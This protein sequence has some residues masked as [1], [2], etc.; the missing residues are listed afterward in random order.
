MGKKRSRAAGGRPVRGPPAVQRLNEC[1]E[2]AVVDEV[3]GAGGSAGAVDWAALRQGLLEEY[4]GGLQ[5]FRLV[6]ELGRVSA[7]MDLGD[8][9]KD[10]FVQAL[11][12]FPGEA[13][14]KHALASLSFSS[15]LFQMGRFETSVEYLLNALE[16]PPKPFEGWEILLLMDLILTEE[17]TTTNRKKNRY[18]RYLKHA[19]SDAFD[20]K[21]LKDPGACNAH[22]SAHAWIS[23]PSTW[24]QVGKQCARHGEFF[25]ARKCI[26]RGL[27][28]RKV[29]SSGD[30]WECLASIYFVENN[31]EQAIQAAGSGFEIDPFHLGIR[32]RLLAWDPDQ[33]GYYF[34]QE[35]EAIAGIQSRVR[36]MLARKRF[37]RI[38]DKRCRERMLIKQITKESV[39]IV[40]GN[41]LRSAFV[42]H[43]AAICIQK[44]V[45]RW[46][47]QN[48]VGKLKYQ[49]YLDECANKIQSCYR[50]MVVRRKMKASLQRVRRLRLAATT[51]QRI[52]RGNRG[53]AKA[54][55]V[56][57]RLCQAINIQ[58][59]TR[60]MFG[61][62]VARAIRD[63]HSVMFQKV[64]RGHLVRIGVRQ[65]TRSR[66]HEA[67]KL[68]WT[69]LEWRA[70]SLHHRSNNERGGGGLEPDS[71]FL[72]AE[73]VGGT[74]YTNG[75]A[76]S[77][78]SG[79]EKGRLTLG[80]LKRLFLL[81]QQG[82]DNND[83]E[84]L[85]L[86]ELVQAMASKLPHEQVS[87]SL[88]ELGLGACNTLSSTGMGSL[89]TALHDGA[90]QSLGV[91]HIENFSQ[92]S[93]LGMA[94]ALRLKCLQTSC[95]H[96]ISLVSG[97]IGDESCR[98]IVNA[99]KGC[100][101]LRTLSLE[102][103]RICDRGAMWLT[104]LFQSKSS[105]LREI[106]LNGNRIADKGVLWLTH[107]MQRGV[108]HGGEI[109]ACPIEKLHL[110]RNSISNLGA[111]GIQSALE[112]ADSKCKL[113]VVSLGRNFASPHIL[114]YIAKLCAAN[115]TMSYHVPSSPCSSY[116]P[117][118]LKSSSCAKSTSTRETL[119]TFGLL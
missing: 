79:A 86:D 60:G 98:A 54:H 89:F 66:Q 6:W 30:L 8:A 28:A 67:R 7:C 80:H 35:Q 24:E 107:A 90:C 48:K 10:Y 23:A 73:M 95:I 37:R 84:M 65:S 113:F 39:D 112:S 77:V 56:K 114:A 22:K 92:I 106:N 78:L 12:A 82:N 50:G 52:F 74:V 29:Q 27:C 38:A 41:A 51:I 26:I 119:L 49:L 102:N 36:S 104:H 61:R 88:E 25:L 117:Y 116:R 31:V 21:R 71:L 85:S 68:D 58:R 43:Q 5:S 1:R 64:C 62:H 97:R 94:S 105:C 19:Y 34:Q 109:F 3:L 118:Y 13:K 87:D 40:I 32:R 46:Q 55:R 4:Q 99:F 42:W 16:S 2:R 20:Q 100:V 59:V 83:K 70:R 96:T 57:E 44:N 91:L 81:G 72:V 93:D 11:C 14:R 33:W 47:A 108:K 9:A 69:S 103:N 110:E 76:K 75:V 63:R 115:V 53:R 15:L 18:R 111:L 101:S 17:K 45:R